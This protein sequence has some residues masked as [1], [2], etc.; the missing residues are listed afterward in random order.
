MNKKID[1]AIAGFGTACFVLSAYI[2]RITLAM[3][4]HIRFATGIE[5][6]LIDSFVLW[7]ILG[8]VALK[9]LLNVNHPLPITEAIACGFA[10]CTA[11]GVMVGLVN[12]VVV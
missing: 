6:L 8:I 4:A 3:P 11:V 7:G 12:W 2:A 9:N 5:G 1:A 10:F